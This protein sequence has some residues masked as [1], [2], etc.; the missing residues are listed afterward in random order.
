MKKKEF[1]R[2]GRTIG[3]RSDALERN[4]ELKRSGER[5]GIV[6]YLKQNGD[7]IQIAHFTLYLKTRDNYLARQ[8][9]NA[10]HFVVQ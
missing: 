10:R 2:A 3:K 6:E 5:S 7:T 8:D 4:L 1:K 9:I